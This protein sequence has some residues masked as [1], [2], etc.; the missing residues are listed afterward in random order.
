MVVRVARR[1][2]RGRGKWLE[3]RGREDETTNRAG[4]G[5]HGFEAK[6]EEREARSEEGLK[7]TRGRG[8]EGCRAEGWGRDC[9]ARAARGPGKGRGARN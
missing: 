6:G 1:G 3:A 4:R 9:R 5:K 7:G 2:R 8:Y